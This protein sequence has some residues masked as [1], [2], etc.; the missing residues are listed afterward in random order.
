MA[1]FQC[2]CG[3]VLS[4]SL[5]PNNIELRV[6]TDR[7]WDEIINCDVLEPITIPLPRYEVWRCSKCERIYV[8][9]GNKVIKT[10]V[11]EID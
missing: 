10:Y 6:Y 4:N 9:D 1:R 5:A 3:E 7:E 11:L 2:K 8:F